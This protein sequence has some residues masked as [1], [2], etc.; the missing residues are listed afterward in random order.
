MAAITNSYASSATWHVSWNGNSLSY[1][2]DC[3][4]SEW[5]PTTV[6]QVPSLTR[7]LEKA[8]RSKQAMLDVRSSE[9]RRSGR[10]VVRTDR[11]L[12]TAQAAMDARFAAGCC[13]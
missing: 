8:Q 12:Q 2:D 6:K 5:I 1:A 3:S 13:R 10:A 4:W 11:R 7:K 9:R